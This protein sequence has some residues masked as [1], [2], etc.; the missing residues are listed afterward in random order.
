MVCSREAS[1]GF[2][3][4]TLREA[5]FNISPSGSFSHNNIR[6]KILMFLISQKKL[7]RKIRKVKLK[8]EDVF[9]LKFLPAMKD[10]GVT[11]TTL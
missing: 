11:S 6:L 8:L 10:V 5:G 4:H 3:Q 2:L 9:Y 7:M 1:P